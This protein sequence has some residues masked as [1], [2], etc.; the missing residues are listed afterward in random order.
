MFQQNRRH[1]KKRYNYVKL[2]GYITHIRLLTSYLDPPEICICTNI[3]LPHLSACTVET[4][5]K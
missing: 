1:T 5:K 2:P 3:T 4:D